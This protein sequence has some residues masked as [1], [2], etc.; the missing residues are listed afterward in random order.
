KLPHR[1]RGKDKRQQD[2]PG[3]D[4]ID[5]EFQRRVNMPVLMG[6]I[7]I[8]AMVMLMPMLVAMIMSVLMPVLEN[9]L[10]AGRHRHVALR[11][12][13]ERLAEQQHQRRSRE[14]EQGNQPDEFEKVHVVP[15][16][17]ASRFHPPAPF[18]YF[19]TARSGCPAPPPLR[20]P[21]R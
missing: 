11:L 1:A 19:G 12:R 10:H 2:H 15:N 18:P 5:E 6:V 9:G 7:V 20:P 8:V 3:A 17:S 16:T 21:R 14:R 4:Q 13:I